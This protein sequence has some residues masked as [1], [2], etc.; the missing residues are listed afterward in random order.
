MTTS[1][2]APA[3]DTPVLHDAPLPPMFY[4]VSRRKLAILYLATFT[5]YTFYWFYKHWDLY[6]GRHPRASMFGTTIWPVQR[7]IFPMFFT[8][9]LFARVKAHG[10]HVPRVARWHSGWHAT[11]AV[12]WMVLSEVIDRLVGGTAGDVVSI[13]CIFPLLFL[14]LHAQRMVNLACGD[15][16]GRAND[17]LTGAN[18]LWIGLGALAWLV[19]IA[20]LVMPEAGMGG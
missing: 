14:L 1:S 4:V 17:R 12:A 18:K 3:D 9:A 7:A 20:G 8:H 5:L 13:A 19:A 11:V 16:D 15:P 10:R 6:K 2:A